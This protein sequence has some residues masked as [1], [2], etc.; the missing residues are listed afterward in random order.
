MILFMWGP[1]SSQ[2]S[3]R[4]E[5]AWWMPGVWGVG[6]KWVEVSVWCD[7]KLSVI[8]SEGC[9]TVCMYLLSLSCTLKNVD[10][11]KFYVPCILLQ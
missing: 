2:E 6:V 3:Y 1:Q 7:K 4:Q 5:V 9:L 11:G 8:H 10:D